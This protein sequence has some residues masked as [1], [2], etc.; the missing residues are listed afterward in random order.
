MSKNV[1][2]APWV[3]THSRH[4]CIVLSIIGEPAHLIFALKPQ[5]FRPSHSSFQ[6]TGNS[7][8]PVA[9]WETVTI[10]WWGFH[11]CA[12]TIRTLRSIS[13]FYVVWLYLKLKFQGTRLTIPGCDPYHCIHNFST[14]CLIV[15]VYIDVCFT[16]L[17]CML[18]FFWIHIIYVQVHIYTCVLVVDFFF[19]IL[20]IHKMLVILVWIIEWFYVFN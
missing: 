10:S 12:C 14:G 11:E 16:L 9:L 2:G 4:K 15:R 1:F 20:L 19:Y 8:P 13:A 18:R 6:R 7:K 17:F 3:S 5:N